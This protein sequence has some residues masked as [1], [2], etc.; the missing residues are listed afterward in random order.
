MQ[1]KTNATNRYTMEVS[2]IYN[3]ITMKRDTVSVAENVQTLDQRTLSV[4]AT[5]GNSESTGNLP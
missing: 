4:S 1:L 5:H 2:L 3:G